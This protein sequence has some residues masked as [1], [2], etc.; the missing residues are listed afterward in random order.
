ME[1]RVEIDRLTIETKSGKR[2]INK[3]SLSV[4]PGELQA[5]QGPSGCGKTTLLDLIGNRIQSSLKY[6]GHIQIN[7][8]FKYVPQEEH[9]HGFYTVQ[10]Y[11]RHYLH[12]NYGFISEEKQN[13]I[14]DAVL[15]DTGLS[16]SKD[17]RVG[18]I[19]LKGLSGG[20]KRRLSI[21]LEL[22]GKPDILILDEP[23]SG[24][25]SVSAYYVMLMLKKLTVEG[26]TVI[27]TLHQP[28]SQIYE[29][30][31]KITFITRGNICFH[32]TTDQATAFFADIG[33]V[34]PA[35]FNPSDYFLFQINTDFNKEIHP[36][37]L[38]SQYLEWAKRSGN[39]NPNQKFRAPFSQAEKGM[40]V[41]ALQSVG[42]PSNFFSKFLFLIQRYFLNLF[43]NPGIILVRL[44]MYLILC[45]II[46]FMYFQLGS[47]YSQTDIVSRTS[48]LFFVDAFLVF[49]SIAVL[50]FFM[51][52]RG[53]V[54]KEVHNKLYSP[55]HYQVAMFL[56]SVPGVAII[57]I[58]SSL[59]VNLIAN[60]NGFGVFFLILFL[61]LVCGESLA[62][63][64]SL[65]VPHYIIGMAIIAGLYGVFMICQGFLIVR[66]QIP[67]YFIWIY[68]L[69]FFTYSFEG[70][71]VN[72]FEPIQK[73]D[74]SANFRTGKEVLN[75]YGMDGKKVW[76]DALILIGYA[77]ILQVII[78][79]IMLFLFRRKEIKSSKTEE[80]IEIEEN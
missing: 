78:A 43:M 36:E 38:H 62:M 73:F 16:N 71:M 51:I 17:T 15:E 49:M 31:D 54:E 22:I 72:E 50:P 32:G 45:F 13:N 27:C 60:L 35:H 55:I 33:K 40:T 30:L 19:F 9:L 6:T 10:N 8:S 5:I 21:A 11:V 2:I 57:A 69:G 53:I 34:A 56:T 65:V 74:D 46:G 12:L 26:V 37:Q 23:T 79:V 41:T 28:S 47:Y 3:I 4:F 42:E 20:Q 25:D 76:K 18:D 61:S 67:G 66:D 1:K 29:M 48:L 64:V 44:A 14:I 63:L 39:N 24:L 75:F 59:L 52:E 68:Y 70:F 58:V 77:L 80:P 7:G